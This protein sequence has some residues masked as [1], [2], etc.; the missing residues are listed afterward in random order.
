MLTALTATGTGPL[1]DATDA[2]AML[3]RIYVEHHTYALRLAVQLTGDQPTAEDVVAD[4]FV[5]LFKRL[6]RGPIEYPRAYLRRAV[7]NQRNSWFRRNVLE[8]A[9][10]VVRSGDDRGDLEATDALADRDQ[11]LSAMRHLTE[12][13]R[14]VLVLRYYEDLS[15]AAT[16]DVLGIAEG[17]VKTT[18]HRAM[19]R[20]EGLLSEEVRT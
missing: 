20:L 17:T 7:I 12:R 2:R 10:A 14:Q 1:L 4:V 18:T 3:D 13:Q 8:R 9:R 6:Q 19:G 5:K 11:M 15:V 16:A